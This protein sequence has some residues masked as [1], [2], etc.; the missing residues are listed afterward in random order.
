[1]ETSGRISRGWSGWRSTRHPVPNLSACS[2]SVVFLPAS[3]RS[4]PQL[5]A[6]IYM[7]RLLFQAGLPL[8]HVGNFSRS[9]RWVEQQY[10]LPDPEAPD[11]GQDLRALMGRSPYLANIPILKKALAGP[12]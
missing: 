1:M 7:E 6:F 3:R 11:A 2:D 12:A 9:M 4:P 5:G 10:S 8:C